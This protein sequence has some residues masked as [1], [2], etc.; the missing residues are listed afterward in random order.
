MVVVSFKSWS[1]VKPMQHVFANWL[2][3]DFASQTWQDRKPQ[4]WACISATR[5]KLKIVKLDNLN[6]TFIQTKKA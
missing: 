2:R 3:N 1:W 4:N 6:I 5:D